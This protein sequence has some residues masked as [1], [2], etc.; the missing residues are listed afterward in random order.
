MGD[1][2]LYVHLSLRCGSECQIFFS[3]LSPDFFPLLP[4][5]P[6]YRI[7]LHLSLYVFESEEGDDNKCETETGGREG[8][9]RRGRSG[10]VAAS[11][12]IK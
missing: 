11:W 12:F 9:G 4:S 5:F 3:E 10:A 6:R 1:V 8:G 2:N 7:G